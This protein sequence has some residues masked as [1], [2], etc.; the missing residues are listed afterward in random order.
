M[1]PPPVPNKPAA[2]PRT[3]KPNPSETE[4]EEWGRESMARESV[5]VGTGDTPHLAPRSSSSAG[6]SCA[7]GNEGASEYGRR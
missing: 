4:A 1:P 5:G 2:E 6:S 3:A 7:S